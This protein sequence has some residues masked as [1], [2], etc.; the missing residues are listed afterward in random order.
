[1]TIHTTTNAS[2]LLP[3][4][5]VVIP[6]YNRVA[7]LKEALASL[8]AQDYGGL[9]EIIVVDDNSQDGTPTIIQEG[10]SDVNLIAL[11]KNIGPAAARNRGISIAKG[12]FVAF[13]D[14]DDLWQPNYLQSQISLLQ[15]PE[16]ATTENFGVSDIFIWNMLSD[17]K[18]RKSQKPKTKYSSTLHHLLSG[19]SFISTPS[20][21]VFP[22]HLLEEIG[23][24][25]ESLR[26]GEDTDLYTRAV[27]AGYSPLFT[28][29]ASVVRRKHGNEQAM[30]IENIES[31][32]QN[33]LRAAKK[34]YPSAKRRLD[35][36]TL[37]RIYAEIYTNFAS[38]YYRD[39]CYLDW[40][41]LS[42]SSA[43]HSSL[44]EM[45]HNIVSDIRDSTKDFIRS[46][47]QSTL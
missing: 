46:F 6:T 38:H 43:R 20:A 39:D 23:Y 18:Y 12:R 22:R 27:L 36:I 34:Y 7:M 3:D 26:L 29:L 11:S 31:R 17:R 37:Q 19:G 21:V 32:V 2:T 10:Y 1:M 45:T 30:T 5:S 25:D 42:L 13:L 4:V 47:K 35:N 15:R 40:I 28:E 14:S 16:N 44:Q 41:R 9:I 33:R 24:F 8:Y